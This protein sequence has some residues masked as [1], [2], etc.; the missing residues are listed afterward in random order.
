MNFTEKI[1][2]VTA[3]LET[4]ASAPAIEGWIAKDE[5][6]QMHFFAD[7]PELVF[8]DALSKHYWTP[9]IGSLPI[10]YPIEMN[11]NDEPRRM[12]LITYLYPLG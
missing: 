1:K 11:F 9:T 12:S 2:D 7:K 4:V 10:D 3:F 5:D 8:S 6:G